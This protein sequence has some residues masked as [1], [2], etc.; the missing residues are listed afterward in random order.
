MS[1]L[2]ITIIS[3]TL[4]VVLGI[5][6]SSY[7]SQASFKSKE[8]RYATESGLTKLKVMYDI[9][10]NYKECKPEVDGWQEAFKEFSDSRNLPIVDRG[11]FA[12]SFNKSGNEYYFCLS[13]DY[14]NAAMIGFKRAKSD[15]GTEKL[16]ISNVC[17]ATVE[18]TSINS[19]TLAITYWM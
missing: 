2:I 12:W 19:G 18:N 4:A 17:G 1:N 8:Y 15:L 14:N 9:Y 13:G 6:G 11:N 10:L 5:M 3:I 7:I 16:V